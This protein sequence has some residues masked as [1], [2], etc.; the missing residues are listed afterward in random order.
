MTMRPFHQPRVSLVS[1]CMCTGHIG[2]S[3]A[4]SKRSTERAALNPLD[5]PPVATHRPSEEQSQKELSHPTALLRN[6]RENH[7]CDQM[8]GPPA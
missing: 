5:R 1:C 7:A 3:L 8:P 2:Q 6:P 4:V